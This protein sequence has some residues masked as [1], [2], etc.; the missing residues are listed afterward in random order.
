MQSLLVIFFFFFAYCKSPNLIYTKPDRLRYLQNM[1][2]THFN[3]TYSLV[4]GAGNQANFNIHRCGFGDCLRLYALHNPFQHVLSVLYQID[5]GSAALI[6]QH[7][8]R[9]KKF[10]DC[11]QE[12]YEKATTTQSHDSQWMKQLLLPHL[13][14]FYQ[15]SNFG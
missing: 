3:V 9:V 8:E 10:A 14:K 5:H 13:E 2:M 15:V 12:E 11:L 6:K 7:H 1:C 4:P